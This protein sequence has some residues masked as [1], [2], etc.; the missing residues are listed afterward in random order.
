MQGPPKATTLERLFGVRRDGFCIFRSQPLILGAVRSGLPGWAIALVTFA[1]LEGPRLIVAIGQGTLY[2]QVDVVQDLR[3]I[4][5]GRPIEPG[6]DAIPLLRD[7]VDFAVVLLIAL[8]TGRMV[9]QWTRLSR[10][11]EALRKG[12]LL[13][14]SLADEETFRRILERHERRFNSLLLEVL[15]LLAATM[16]SAELVATVIPHGIYQRLAGNPL[17]HLSLWWASPIAHPVAFAIIVGSYWFYLYVVVRHTVVGVLMLGMIWDASRVAGRSGESWIEFHSPLDPVEP[18][19][20][21]LRL[22]IYDVLASI[23][24]LVPVFSAA[25]LAFDLPVWVYLLVA[26]P[27][28]VINPFFAILPTFFINRALGRSRRTIYEAAD[29]EDTEAIRAL[30][31][32]SP[33][34]PSV[35]A[36]RA[37]AAQERLRRV[38]LM[39][40]QIISW[41][42]VAGALI[43]YALPLV[44]LLP[45]VLDK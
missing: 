30:E 3:A 29:R 16:V 24:L 43:V 31:T 36:A 38:S 23:T 25:T 13:A 1:A 41:T 8:H 27:F 4:L 34:R 19:L 39:P 18:A 22:G 17:D 10:L 11:P 6:T 2:V 20:N 15:A 35:I 12:G 32:L 21:E 28:V 44:L 42:H 7:Y 33:R 37:M 26:A 5:L 14:P 40:T 45:V 9:G